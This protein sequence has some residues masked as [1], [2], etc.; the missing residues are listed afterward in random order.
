MEG[1][2]KDTEGVSSFFKVCIAWFEYTA[3]FP[4]HVQTHFKAW[5][6]IVRQVP[7]LVNWS[8]CC[9]RN[10]Q[11]SLTARCHIRYVEFWQLRCSVFTWVLGTVSDCC[12]SALAGCQF[13]C[14]CLSALAGCQFVCGCCLHWLGVSLCVDVICTGWVSACV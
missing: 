11:S 3:M 5:M 6:R 2:H 9:H 1:C 10:W 8:A 4:L 7:E 12:L 13:V 14:G